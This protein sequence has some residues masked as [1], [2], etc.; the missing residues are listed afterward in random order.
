MRRLLTELILGKRAC[1]L[2]FGFQTTVVQEPDMGCVDIAFEDLQ[3]VALEL[4]RHSGGAFE[5]V[6]FEIRQ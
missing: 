3:P 5:H 1:W 4:E 6:G 2:I